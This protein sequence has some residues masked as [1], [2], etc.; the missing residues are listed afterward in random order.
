MTA[1]GARAVD[2]YVAR[3]PEAMQKLL[4]RVRTAIRRAIPAAD[5]AISYQIPAFKLHG[6]AVIY[7]AGWKQHYSVYPANE[8]LVAR[9]AEELAPY[10]VS[11][12]TIRFP[13]SEPV[14]VKLIAGIALFLAAEAG[15]RQRIRSAEAKKGR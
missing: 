3:Q 13:I 15:E 1:I 4:R 10:E 12:G 9:F 14:P 5:E 6:R 8:R 2:E 7:F 11:K